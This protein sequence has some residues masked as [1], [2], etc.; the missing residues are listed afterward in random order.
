[1]AS[2]TIFF[3]LIKNLNKC[4]GLDNYT[5]LSNVQSGISWFYFYGIYLSYSYIILF[6]SSSF[7]PNVKYSCLSERFSVKQSY[8]I[9]VEQVCLAHVIP[10]CPLLI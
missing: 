5:L 6:Y 7:L 2:K 4:N 10:H 9:Q 1:M 8:N 3:I